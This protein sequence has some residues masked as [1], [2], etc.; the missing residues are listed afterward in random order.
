MNDDI[1][2]FIDKLHKRSG[3]LI[4]GSEALR[5]YSHEII[6]N[7]KSMRSELQGLEKHMQESDANAGDVAKALRSLESSLDSLQSQMDN[8]VRFD[9]AE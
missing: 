9:D 6:C 7:L 1:M 3:A 2:S 8:S 4:S 5:M